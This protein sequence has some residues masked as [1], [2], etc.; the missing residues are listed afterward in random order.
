M[1]NWLYFTLSIWLLVFSQLAYAQT[2]VYQDDFEGSVSGWSVNDT[3]FDPDTT[4]FLGPFDVNG[5]STSRTFNVPAGSTQL[6]IEFDLYRFD[7]WDNFA[8]F[9]FDRF[10]IDIDGTQI[11]SLPFPN[12]QASRSGTTGNV[13]W[14][15]SPLTGTVEVAYESGQFWFDQLHRFEVIVNNPGAT[16]DLTLRADLSQPF[17]DESAA[18]D[19]FLV[20]ADPPTTG[21]P[22]SGGGGGVCPAG[23][24]ATPGTFHVVS[25][26]GGNS[27]NLTIGQPQAEGSTQ[28]NGAVTFFGPITMDLTGDPN[29]LVPEGE[30]IEVVLSSH[31]GTSARAEILMSADGVNYTSLGTTGNGGSVYGAWQ[32]N[33]LRYDDFIVP[34]GGA[35]FLQVMHQAS[36][37][38]ADGVIYNTQCQPS[39]AAVSELG[40]AKSAA[41]P[42]LNDNGTYDVTY[43]IVM[44]NTGTEVIDNLQVN[45]NIANLMGASF[46]VSDEGIFNNGVKTG[47]SVMLINTSGSSTAP[48][49]ET[50][51]YDGGT[52]TS[53]LRGTDGTLAPG[54]QV[55]ITFTVILNPNVLAPP[56]AFENI[57]EGSG[58]DPTGTSIADVSDNG[59]DP[60]ANP[61][62]NTGSP[63]PVILPTTPPD[64]I[65]L[66]T[67]C[68]AFN[69]AGWLTN[70]SRFINSNLQFGSGDP[71]RDPYTFTGLL[72]DADG[73]I[74]SFLG[75]PDETI[76][77]SIPTRA[78]TELAT[79]TTVGFPNTEG[80]Y[81]LSVFRLEGA[82]NTAESVTFDGSNASDHS[83]VW[84]EDSAGNVIYT[85]PA[86]PDFIWTSSLGAGAD[87]SIPFT[88][89][90]DGI[91]YVYASVYDPTSFY[92]QYTIT[93]YECPAPSLSIDK[94][95]SS[96][97]P[98]TVGDVITYT[99]T[100]T[101]DGNQTIRDVVINDTHN[102]SDPAPMPSNETLFTD[103]GTAGDSTDSTIDGSWD[104]LAPGDTITFTGSYT[105]TL[106]DAGNL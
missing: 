23:T 90:A 50:A 9:G 53:L 51:D 19:N 15:H 34:A 41:A 78:G 98:F 103:G 16:V 12:P 18:F 57:A 1:R 20:T 5:T 42:V 91:V 81:H 75:T 58:S 70:S 87:F 35:R 67:Q 105:V 77:G 43:T 65:A 3:D 102:G 52:N 31:F 72:N 94:V 97:G 86:S 93:D 44:E 88:Y 2:V 37:V 82:P 79:D 10:E 46:V 4:T 60:S 76:S 99:Y 73:R 38:R 24:V 14:T 69:H 89:P 48:T 62:E 21:S 54:D 83:Y 11:F 26:T 95:A 61:G 6:V 104:V 74:L 22:P 32:S 47:P 66:P 8:M 63:T 92:S 40:V 100:V 84:I 29:I 27:P 7:S 96:T 30:L 36:G 59:T 71:A 45:D 25:A 106:I 80:E 39:V 13:D 68:G 49:A 64:I 56:A 17:T 85:V 101:N 33:I 28:T 55:E